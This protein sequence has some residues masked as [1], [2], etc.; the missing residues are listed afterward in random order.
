[1]AATLVGYTEDTAGD[2]VCLAV[3]EPDAEGRPHRRRY[4]TDRAGYA[5]LGCPVSGSPLSPEAMAMLE[6]RS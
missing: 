1:M 3:S 6:R 2:R 5:Q 4:Y